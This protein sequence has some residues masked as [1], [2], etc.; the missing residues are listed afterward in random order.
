MPYQRYANHNIAPVAQWWQPNTNNHISYATQPLKFIPDFSYNTIQA[1]AQDPKEFNLNSDVHVT[2]T[3]APFH[4]N[5][6]ETTPTV[7]TPLAAP[8]SQP[9]PLID[10]WFLN[11]DV[12][13]HEEQQQQN[14][15]QRPQDSTAPV[16]FP[17]GAR[18]PLP[19]SNFSA[20]VV[21]KYQT[22]AS[23]TTPVISADYYQS[24]DEPSRNLVLAN[25][26][27]QYFNEL[28]EPSKP[29]L[30]PFGPL[31]QKPNLYYPSSSYYSPKD[32]TPITETPIE[33][34]SQPPH[35]AERLTAAG[36][37]GYGFVPATLTGL[38]AAP[39]KAAFVVPVMT[40]YQQQ[41]HQ[42]HYPQY[43]A[44][45][46]HHQQQQHLNQHPVPVSYSK[47]SGAIDPEPADVS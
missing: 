40:K 17:L 37:V 10:N 36:Q 27:Q 38:V 43:P 29:T 47:F 30:G 16:L 12:Q 23:I 5:I 6:P 7:A 46:Y 24:P 45:R 44:Q 11:Q 42:Q 14:N 32:H 35:H 3:A 8:E 15:Q 28:D 2:N 9:S 33:E 34:E 1:S 19:K 4:I 21:N 31:A 22:L 26:V 13:E 20:A 39:L 25:N 18:L 41:Q